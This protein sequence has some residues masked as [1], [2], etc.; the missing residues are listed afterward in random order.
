MESFPQLERE[1]TSV[2]SSP[3]LFGVGHKYAAEC[4]TFRKLF[5]DNPFPGRTV[6]RLLIFLKA[7]W[8]KT[9]PS[10][11]PVLRD[12]LKIGRGSNV[13]VGRGGRR[14]DPISSQKLRS[15]APGSIFYVFFCQ[16]SHDMGEENMHEGMRQRDR[17]QVCPDFSCFFSNIVDQI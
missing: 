5:C 15:L 8:T 7:V 12:V 4:R 16:D 3:S 6:R 17:G 1:S 14:K 11:H 9:E 13:R 2:H 10:I